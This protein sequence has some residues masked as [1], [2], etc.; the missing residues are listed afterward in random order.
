MD[1]NVEQVVSYLDD[2]RDEY[3]P[4]RFKEYA[5][6]VKELMPEQTYAL[7][8]EACSKLTEAQM[9]MRKAMDQLRH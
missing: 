1:A 9:S 5:R 8:E 6:E 4:M 2:I 3:S 7:L